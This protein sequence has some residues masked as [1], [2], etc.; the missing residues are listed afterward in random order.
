MTK[1]TPNKKIK[2]EKDLIKNKKNEK[3]QVQMLRFQI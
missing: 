3:D 1:K 2:I